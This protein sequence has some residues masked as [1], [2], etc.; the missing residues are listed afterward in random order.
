MRGKQKS[1]M[2]RIPCFT[3]NNLVFIQ[4]DVYVSG[5]VFWSYSFCFIGDTRRSNITH[6]FK[7][8]STYS[9]YTFAKVT[10]IVVFSFVHT[11]D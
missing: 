1:C 4:F 10:A 2:L 8:A 11:I 6:A 7:C 3:V 9:I 5:I